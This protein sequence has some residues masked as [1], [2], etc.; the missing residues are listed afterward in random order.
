MLTPQVPKGG[1]ITQGKKGKMR[2]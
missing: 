2:G 1:E